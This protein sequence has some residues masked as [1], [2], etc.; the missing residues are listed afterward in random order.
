MK[1]III[2]TVHRAKD[3]TSFRI[4]VDQSKNLFISCL[5]LLQGWHLLF[6]SQQ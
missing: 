3:L 6:Q 5:N 1:K 4:S 2:K